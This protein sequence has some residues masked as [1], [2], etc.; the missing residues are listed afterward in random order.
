MLKLNRNKFQTEKSKFQDMRKLV[1][2]REQKLSELL[3]SNKSTAGEKMP[4][5]H[6]FVLTFKAA[7]ALF[8]SVRR[9]K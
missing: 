9:L 1:L 5:I 7:S 4:I 3:K 6:R 8:R 2:R